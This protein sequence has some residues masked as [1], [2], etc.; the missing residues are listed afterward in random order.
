LYEKINEQISS[1]YPDNNLKK[2][3]PKKTSITRAV[4]RLAKLWAP[5]DKRLI[6]AAVQIG[7]NSSGEAAMARSPAHRMAAL[8]SGWSP[9]FGVKEVNEKEARNFCEKWCVPAQWHLAHPATRRCFTSFLKSVQHASPG[10]DGVP[11]CAW[12]A[13]GNDGA[14]TLWL[15]NQHLASGHTMPFEF[16]DQ[17]M[18]FAAKGEEPE[19]AHEV[20]RAPGDTRPL[21]LKNTDNNSIAG[22]NNHLAK[23]ML[24]ASVV[25]IQRGYV[26]GRQLVANVLDLDTYGRW[27]GAAGHE[28]FD[29]SDV[30]SSSGSVEP[31]AIRPSVWVAPKEALK[32][33]KNK[34]VAPKNALKKKR[35][36]PKNAL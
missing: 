34:R 28:L 36:A 8:S 21:S 31:A 12:E 24:T 4:T 20:C 15:V 5:T 19:D 23:R 6:L 27:Y 11:Y 1:D 17:L 30:P 9:T 33:Q 13:A 16:S 10:P 32:I 3:N 18:I 29:L 7:V 26:P 14:E 25:D 2:I 22:V 35:V